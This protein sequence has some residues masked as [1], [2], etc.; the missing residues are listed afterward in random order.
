MGYDR[1]DMAEGKKNK[2]LEGEREGGMKEG[3]S[4]PLIWR[5]QNIVRGGELHAGDKVKLHKP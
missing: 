2:G 3:R 1:D 5:Q 4:Q